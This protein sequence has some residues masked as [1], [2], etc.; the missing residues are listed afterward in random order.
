MP[1]S[2]NRIGVKYGLAFIGVALSLWLVAAADALLVNALRERVDAFS[3][4]F[5]AATV[6]VMGAHRDLYQARSAEN[7]YLRYIPG[8]PESK[9]AKAA[10]QQSVE[11]AR[12]GMARFRAEMAGYPAVLERTE[13]FAERFQAWRDAS[14]ATFDYY[15]D[16]NVVRAS[17]QID[18]DSLDAFQAL[19]EAYRQASAAVERTTGALAAR[20]AAGIRRQ[21]LVVGGFAGLVGLL[22]MALALIGPHLMAKAIRQVSRRIGEITRGDG[23]LTARVDSPRGDEIGELA[24]EFDA[25]IG[26]IDTTLQSVRDN[27]VGVST[28]AEDMARGSQDL[29][30]RTEQSAANLQQTS[31]S[32]E[33]ITA[34][35]RGTAGATD[36]AGQL[37]RSAVDVVRRGQGA[38]GE[39]ETTM[40]EISEASA[41]IN[42][43]IALIDGIAFQTNILALNASVEAARAGEHGKGFAV[44]AEEVR[45]LAG[46]SGE[47]SRDI[48]ALVDRSAGA[49]DKGAGLVRRAGRTMEEIV[50]SIDRVSQVIGDIGAGAREQNQGIDQV[51]TAVAELDAMTQHNAAMV[52][53]GSAAADAMR[54]QAAVLADLI[55][56]FR[57]T[58][59]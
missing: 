5:H 29:A 20:T 4:P 44:V 26:R 34:T 45:T 22:A 13:G 8:T 37:V 24:R 40:Q 6:A 28:A 31:A 19:G 38:M 33:Q 41:R 9:A 21:R 52:E 47:A 55:A 3:G 30:A 43:I 49:T 48:R 12:Q 51:N 17:Q 27:A 46:R 56:G 59:S 53:Q 54:R 35:V 10:Y 58:G 50:A 1:R 57:L 32:M 14:Q 42:E 2:L 18:R 25:F 11:G 7:E 39:V 16:Q 36:Q 23:D 15:D